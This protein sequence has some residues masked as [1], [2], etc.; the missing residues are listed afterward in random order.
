MNDQLEDRLLTK[1]SVTLIK[2]E[3]ET[4]LKR[5]LLAGETN[6]L[7]QYIKELKLNTTNYRKAVLY[8]VNSYHN[9]LL[10]PG[11]KKYVNMHELMKT[12]LGSSS[13]DVS[14]D[15]KT[16]ESFASLPTPYGGGYVRNK[17]AYFLLDS[18]FKNLTMEEGIFQWDLNFS[19]VIQQSSV[20][21]VARQL[22]DIHTIQF[23]D[24]SIPYTKSADNAYGRIAVYIEEFNEMS[25]IMNNNKR[26]H[27]LFKPTRETNKIQ[28]SP[29]KSDEGKYRFFTP[30]RAIDSLTLRFLNPF[31]RIQF[32]PDRYQVK[33]RL[34]T[35]PGKT[36]IIFSENHNV[37]DSE[38][39]LIE[40]FTMTDPDKNNR[41][42]NSINSSE[43]YIC[44]VLDNTTLQINFDLVNVQTSILNDHFSKCFI[45]SR[46]ILIP[47]RVL[48]N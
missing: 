20:N 44:E 16:C 42:V 45:A 48:Y 41:T 27:M 38:L 1:S 7:I 6:S 29:L 18:K 11:K 23:D 22:K 24:F 17:S 43:G 19:Q 5:K 39:I 4:K 12:Q 13:Q 32:L 35:L 37:T 3:V 14:G 34:G 40:D 30:V 2:D 9:K 36:I 33:V 28:L 15:V 46:R 10:N 25:V 21:V 31:N 8:I 26:Y 47:L